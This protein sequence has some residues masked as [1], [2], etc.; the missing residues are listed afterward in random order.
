MIK[1]QVSKGVVYLLRFWVVYLVRR[2]VVSLLRR[3][4]GLF[5]PVSGGH[6]DR[7]FHIAHA[8]RDGKYCAIPSLHRDNFLAKVPGRCTVLRRVT[9]P[10]FIAVPLKGTWHHT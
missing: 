1:K 8:H 7:F 5:A 10:P 3:G 6:F 4:G 9:Q 2:R